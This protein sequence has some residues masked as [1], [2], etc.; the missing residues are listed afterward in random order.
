MQ[1]GETDQQKVTEGRQRYDAAL[2]AKIL[3]P[4][5][6]LPELIVLAGWMHVFSKAFLEPIEKAGVR[7]INLHPALPGKFCQR[8]A[9]GM[10]TYV[11]KGRL[12]ELGRLSALLRS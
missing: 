11:A 12:M 2:A 9:I 5:K 8:M 7:I 6:E 10:V 3:S 1:K 4:G